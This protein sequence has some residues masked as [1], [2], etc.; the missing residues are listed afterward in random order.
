MDKSAYEY[1]NGDSGWWL[2]QQ[3]KYEWKWTLD[4]DIIR[5][6]VIYVELFQTTAAETR[7]KCSNMI[8]IISRINNE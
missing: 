8:K 6:G 2:W 7:H 3:N 4:K 5:D 1:D